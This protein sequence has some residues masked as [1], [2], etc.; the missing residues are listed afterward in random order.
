MGY[1]HLRA[2][3]TLAELF[4]TEITRMDVPPIAG[5]IE[6][7]AWRAARK[8]YNA[9]SRACELPVAGRAARQIL[10]KIT[11]IAPLQAPAMREPATLFTRLVD[12][13][14][15]TVIGQ[16]FRAVASSAERP[17]LATYPIAAMA[18]SH[19]SPARVCCLT[20]DTDLN[21]AWAPVN[22]AQ[23]S[24]DYFAS[25]TRVAERLRSFGVPEH[26]IH[27][28]GFPLPAKL[29]AQARPALARRLHRLDPA[30]AFHKQAPECFVDLIRRPAA[31][32][33][34]PPISMTIAIGGAGAQTAQ[35]GRLIRSLRGQVAAGEMRLTLVAGLRPNVAGI[36]RELVQSAGLA[37]R[38]GN[39]IEI[40]HAND[41]EDYFR[42]F[43][44]CLSDTDL[45]WTK[46]SELAFYAA[47]G[48]PLLLAPPVGSQEHS[49]RDW[50]L[51]H[52]AALD[53]GDPATF[54][55]RFEE[56]LATGE[57]CRI[58]WNAYSRLDRNGSD[59]IVEFFRSS[60]SSP[61][62]RPLCPSKL[63]VSFL[64]TA[65]VSPQT[66]YNPRV[67]R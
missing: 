53:A 5:A 55:R 48:L 7:G 54:G 63:K 38:I 31:H 16:K 40:L 2:A 12:G 1:G 41:W 32:S 39:G 25:V 62:Q 28:T 34:L 51:S 13:L 19:A 26:R 33:P 43:N 21:R 64:G 52:D 23:V 17:I 8:F 60:Y 18:A 65:S 20:T 66:V 30:S 57:F 14:T 36:L 37:P 10:D 11:E 44:E 35:V 67:K 49:N 61:L 46:P 4:G 22:A 3:H 27:I 50:L 29:I 24:I 59:R 42:R 56:L 47:L 45:L 58:A 9:L 15:R 6:T